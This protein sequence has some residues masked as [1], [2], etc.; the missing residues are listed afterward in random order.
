MKFLFKIL[1][2]F[3][4]F[5]AGLHAA[6]STH[7]ISRTMEGGFTLLGFDLFYNKN[8]PPSFPI[9]LGRSLTIKS[10]KKVAHPG[11]SYLTTFVL[12]DQENGNEHT[13][14]SRMINNEPFSVIRYVYEKKR[15]V[16]KEAQGYKGFL[17]CTVVLEDGA[18]Y[19]V[20]YNTEILPSEEECLADLSQIYIESADQFGLRE[21][22][23]NGTDLAR[24]FQVE[25]ASHQKE[26]KFKAT[27]FGHARRSHPHE[28]K[29]DIRFKI[30]DIWGSW[31]TG[32][33]PRNYYIVKFDYFG[34]EGQDFYDETDESYSGPNPNSQIRLGMTL[35]FITS[36][37]ER[38][39]TFFVFQDES[40]KQFI[41]RTWKDGPYPFRY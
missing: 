32:W 29:K 20:K 16:K 5:I 34:H 10:Q 24:W 12:Q 26:L 28:N 36:Y 18:S 21:A 23:G 1:C 8:N 6:N 40:K 33:V 3:S 9:E 31:T 37:K 41:V 19:I 27:A 35:K 4:F 17:E 11:K 14:S 38:S 2:A 13:F 7:P 22:L 15:E 30:V 25:I 39:A